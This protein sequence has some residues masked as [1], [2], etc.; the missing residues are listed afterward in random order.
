MNYERAVTEARTLVKRSSEDQWRLA[1]LT[2]QVTHGPDKR[3]QREWAADLGVHHTTVGRWSRIWEQFGALSTKP[4]WSDAWNQ[5]IGRVDGN[6]GQAEVRNLPPE[7]KAEVARELLEDPEVASQVGA[8]AL[9][10][11]YA[12]TEQSK[13]TERTQTRYRK[14][15]EAKQDAQQL[16]ISPFTISGLIHGILGE[17]AFLEDERYIRDQ[18]NLHLA[19]LMAGSLR[20]IAG[21]I[22]AWVDGRT[23]EQTDQDLQAELQRLVEEARQ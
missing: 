19:T 18:Y 4:Q 17:L 10:K 20:E 11:A 6:Y 8:G 12:E 3:T 1:E 5:E 16:H 2:W 14:E 15:R 13:E 7:R 21:E 23:K 22:E 9:A